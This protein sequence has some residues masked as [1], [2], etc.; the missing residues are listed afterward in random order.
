MIKLKQKK[1]KIKINNSGHHKELIVKQYK[2]PNGKIENFITTNEPSSVVIFPITKENK[3]YLVRQYRP[4]SETEEL[5]LPGGTINQ[6]ENLLE[7]AKREL[8]EETGLISNQLIY[9]GTITY[10]PYSSGLK[11]MFIALN[12]ENTGIQKLDPNEF[13]SVETYS[14]D[15]VKKM[16]KNAKIRGFDCAYMALDYLSE[17]NNKF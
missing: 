16:I 17:L 9:L 15:E 13:L 7:A 2:L 1:V 6:G 3:I 10:N 4:G 5:E 14:M 12:C 8:K 11:N